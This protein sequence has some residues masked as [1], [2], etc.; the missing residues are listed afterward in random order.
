MCA[1]IHANTGVHHSTHMGL[2]EQLMG[3][4]L[5]PCE[6]EGKSSRGQVWRRA[7]LPAS[8]FCH[9]P[10]LYTVLSGVSGYQ[11]QGNTLK[12]S[13]LTPFCP[14]PH[15]FG[16]KSFLSCTSTK[17]KECTNQFQTQRSSVS[18]RFDLRWP[19]SCILRPG[20]CG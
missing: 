7:A 19:H 11:V 2:R 16:L 3:V 12:N 13:Y 17:P 6:F 5:F 8:H 18:A 4:S 1:H 14:P 15:D 9:P 20:C 10:L